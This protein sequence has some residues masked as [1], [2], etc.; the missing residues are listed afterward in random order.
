MRTP[1]DANGDRALFDEREAD[2]TDDLADAYPPR[3]EKRES[4][5]RVVEYSRYPR[6]ARDERRLVGFTRNQ[7]RSGMCIVT[8]DP[9]VEGTLLRLALRTVDGAGTLDA[10]A[11]V[12][13]CERRIDGRYWIGLALLERAG[14]RMLKVRRVEIADENAIGHGSNG[15]APSRHGGRMLES[16]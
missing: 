2:L 13:W 3:E 5:V 12:V 7:S 10:L 14:R 4:V 11:H 8:S 9:E 15:F 1:T 16:A 6:V